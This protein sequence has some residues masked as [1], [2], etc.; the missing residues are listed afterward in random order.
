MTPTA[1]VI[2]VCPC[3]ASPVD[4]AAAQTGTEQHFKCLSCGQ[5]WHMVVDP[6]RLARHSLT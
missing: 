4:A 2:L 6:D 5:S 3:C 1:M